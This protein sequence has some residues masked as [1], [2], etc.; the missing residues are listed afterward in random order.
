MEN[1]SHSGIETENQSNQPLEEI[2]FGEL[3]E[4]PK[5]ITLPTYIQQVSLSYLQSTEEEAVEILG[6]FM[7]RDNEWTHRIKGKGS[8]MKIVNQTIEGVWPLE[9]KATSKTLIRRIFEEFINHK[10]NSQVMFHTHP[11]I[12][13]SIQDQLIDR[14]YPEKAHFNS[15]K[16]RFSKSAN[17]VASTPSASDMRSWLS[18]R[19]MIPASF[20]LS[21]YGSICLVNNRQH[22]PMNFSYYFSNEKFM[23]QLIAYEKLRMTDPSN[24]SNFDL[25]KMN[26]LKGAAAILAYEGLKDHENQAAALYYSN[27]PSKDRLTLVKP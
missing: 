26:V 23:E 10:F 24:I 15:F 21:S 25:H 12:P 22:N 7:Y 17:I 3:K 14:T 2:L 18:G 5:H 8:R 11:T 16:T 19:H 20:I 6:G 9:A 13:E 27:S 1:K 4:F